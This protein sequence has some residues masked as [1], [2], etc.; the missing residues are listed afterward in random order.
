[1]NHV[2]WR[3]N[4]ATWLFLVVAS[5]GTVVLV[6]QGKV[7]GNWTLTF[8]L[9]VAVLKARAIVRYYMEIKFAPWQLRLWFEAWIAVC[10]GV[11]L[12][13]WYFNN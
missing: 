5:I 3:Q 9:A 1:M 7:L 12:G 13:F 10:F 4:V 2:S 6:E 11:I 8:V